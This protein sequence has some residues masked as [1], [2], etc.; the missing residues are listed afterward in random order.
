MAEHWRRRRRLRSAPSTIALRSTH[1]IIRV[2]QPDGTLEPPQVLDLLQEPGTGDHVW[3]PGKRRV[4]V[5]E[6]VR[7]SDGGLRYL[8]AV[9]APPPGQTKRRPDSGVMST[10]LNSSLGVQVEVTAGAA[11][12]IVERGGRLYLWQTNVG[13]GWLRDRL[14]FDLPETPATFRRIPAGL[15]SVMVADNVVLPETLTISVR[16]LLPRR[17]HVEWDGRPWG[18]RGGG[19]WG[20][21]GG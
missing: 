21:G 6:S 11:E 10:S 17:I 1:V 16:R 9:D 5:R 20:G 18:A 7:A 2:R 12:A 14:A 3:L 13:D 4:E 15:I 19:D 8:I